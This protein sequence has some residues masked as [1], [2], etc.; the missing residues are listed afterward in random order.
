[1]VI[2]IKMTR[3]KA[4]RANCDESRRSV[5]TVPIMIG[6]GGGGETVR[7][8]AKRLLFPSPLSVGAAGSS[9]CPLSR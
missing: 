7:V 4:A 9:D 5:P 3:S 2:D 8:A 1:M 6:Q